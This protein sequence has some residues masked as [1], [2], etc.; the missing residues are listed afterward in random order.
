MDY[1]F[2]ISGMPEINVCEGGWRVTALARQRS[3][4]PR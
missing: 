1:D 2:V 3:A 4:V